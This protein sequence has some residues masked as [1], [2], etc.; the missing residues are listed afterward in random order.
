MSMIARGRAVTDRARTGWLL[1]AGVVA[2][3]GIWGLHFVAMLAYRP[4]L[5][6]AYDA[7]LTAFSIVIAASLCAVGFRVCL[8]AAGGAVG[9]A[10]TGSAISAMHYVG[11]AAVRMP[12]HAHWDPAYVTA[13]LLIGILATALA[14]HVAMRRS[15]V[16]GYTIAATLFAIG[17]IGMHFTAMSAVV[18]WPDPTVRVTG[19]VIEPDVLAI[20]VTASVVLIMALG[21]IG[22]LIDNHLAGRATEEAARLRTHIEELESTKATLECTSSSLRTALATADAANQ[23]KSQFLTSMSHELRTPLNAVIGFSEMLEMETFGA[24]GHARYREYAHDIHASGTHLLQLINDILDISRVAAGEVSLRDDDV[25]L[26]AL[27]DQMV[28][29]MADQARKAGV[30]LNTRISPE[31]PRLRGDGRRLQQVLLN[32]VSNAIK[33]TPAGGN[34]TV[35]AEAADAGMILVV[36]DTGIGMKPEQ[37]PLAFERFRQIDNTFSRKYDGA[38][39]GLP[40]ARDLVELHGGRLTLESTP[41]A[42]TTATVS[43]PASRLA[44]P[45]DANTSRELW[46]STSPHTPRKAT[47]AA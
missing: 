7:P 27:I 34:V 36:K 47:V 38:G 6:V 35:G 13:S 43:F 9:G 11:M 45:P 8:S 24:L 31:L 41:N 32:L 20:A 39:L 2:G 4:G 42:G 30:N 17:I 44:S 18:Y 46:L 40:L 28:H 25:D 33:F 10:I 5:P 14:L 12:A 23:A 16:R 15:D 29:M 22:A 26:P 37:I 3:C 19:A 21:M 1:A